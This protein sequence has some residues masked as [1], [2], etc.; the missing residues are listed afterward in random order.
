MDSDFLFVGHVQNKKSDKEAGV[1]FYKQFGTGKT[2]IGST[3]DSY[4]R[5]VSHTS[6]LKRGAHVNRKFQRAFN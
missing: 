5:H 4:G 6:S 1:Y 3:I 2:Y